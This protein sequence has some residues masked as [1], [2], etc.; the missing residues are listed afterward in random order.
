M[1][2]LLMDWK[3]FL[4][5]NWAIPLIRIF[6]CV[7][8]CKC[9]CIYRSVYSLSTISWHFSC[10]IPS[11]SLPLL[12]YEDHGHSRWKPSGTSER[13]YIG[14]CSARYLWQP[15]E[16][17]DHSLLPGVSIPCFY[18]ILL[19][20]SWCE[21][22]KGMRFKSCCSGYYCLY[23]KTKGTTILFSYY[24]VSYTISCLIIFPQTM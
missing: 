1:T 4:A 2:W 24:E 18:L 9:D 3:C 15:N 21:R 20:I 7:C 17:W 16:S 19:E 23:T 13:Y 10:A 12:Q 11:I 6:R 8:G 22:A 5:R 14:P